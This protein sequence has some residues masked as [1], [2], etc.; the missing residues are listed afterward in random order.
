MPSGTSR[1]LLGFCS[2]RL[3]LRLHQ[4]CN[5]SRKF[6]PNERPD[7]A[8]AFAAR[9]SPRAPSCRR[10]LTAR[11]P[12]GRSVGRPAAQTEMLSRVFPSIVRIEAIRLMPFDGHLTKA[13]TAGSGVIITK[14]GHVLTNCH[15]SEDVDAFRCYLYDGQHVDAHRVG[16]DPLTDIAVL[17]L[18]LTQLKKGTGPLPVAVF[19]D[20]DRMKPGDTVFALG[21]PGFLSQSVTQGIVSNPSLVLP[22]RTVGRMMLRG[23]DV[24]MLVRWLLHDASIFGGNSGG[25]L[26]NLRGEVIGVNEIGVF[27]LGGAVPG[28]LARGVAMQLVATG[29]VVRGWSGLTVQE[30]LEADASDTGVVVSDVAAGSPSAKAGIE[31]GDV[32][33]KCDGIAVEGAHEKAIAHYYRLETGCLPGS[34]FTIDYLRAGKP[35]TA[36]FALAVREARA[37][38]TSRSPSGAPWSGDL[39]STVVREELLPDKVGVLDRERP[40]RRPERPGRAGAAARRRHHLARRQARHGRCRTAPADGGDLPGC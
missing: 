34:V 5:G 20:S 11:A 37:R 40:S 26:V 25:P 8:V 38:T 24:G 7:D 4:S 1:A 31:A 10:A 32:V 14:E 33:M 6:H 13:W 15:V 12:G 28:N 3:Q 22:E 30:R 21:S 36:A 2:C 18:D 9:G 17:Q 35:R 19:G 23:E 16:Q 29:R 39:T 27:N